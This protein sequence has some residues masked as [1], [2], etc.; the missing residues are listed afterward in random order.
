MFFLWKLNNI[1]LLRFWDQVD[2]SIEGTLGGHAPIMKMLRNLCFTPGETVSQFYLLT[3][4]HYQEPAYI[5][6]KLNYIKSLF[7]LK[8]P[9]LVV[10]T[11]MQLFIVPARLRCP[12]KNQWKNLF[13]FDVPPGNRTLNIRCAKHTSYKCW[14]ALKIKYSDSQLGFLNC[15]CVDLAR[16]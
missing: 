16:D 12:R 11:L 3:S 5:I 13:F 9:P 14:H 8:M 1:Y 15:L 7:I 2:L 4:H 10:P 6:N